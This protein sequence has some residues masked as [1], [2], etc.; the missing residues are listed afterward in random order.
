MGLLE[1]KRAI[2]TGGSRGIGLACVKSFLAEG[3]SVAAT[4]N[5]A[6]GGLLEL[7]EGEYSERVSVH[8][9]DIRDKS[10]VERI[11]SEMTELLGGLDILVNNAGVSRPSLF[12][13]ITDEQWDE[14]LQ[15]NICGAYLMLKQLLFPMMSKKRGSVINVASVNGLRANPG[16]AAYSA[17]KAALISLTQTLSRELA[18]RG[19]RFNAVA[20]GYVETDMTSAIPAKQREEFIKQIPMKRFGLVAEVADAVTFLASDRASYITGQTLIVDGGLC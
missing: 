12:M 11:S 6:E 4:Y 1:G 19:I 3:A 7:V 14:V 5:S 15:T 18:G 20:P 16:Q 13:T 2:I 9:L 17:S 10:A 8:R